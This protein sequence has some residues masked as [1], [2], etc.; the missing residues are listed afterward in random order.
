MQDEVRALLVRDGA[1]RVVG[2]LARLEV[3]DEA[4]VP[5]LALVL[6]ERVLQGLVADEE[7]ETAVGGGMEELE[8]KALDV[9]RPA[10][11]EPE[12]GRICLTTGTRGLEK[13]DARRWEK[14][15]HTLRRCRTK[16]ASFR[17][18]LR[19]SV[20]CVNSDVTNNI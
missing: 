15:V 11:V 4:L 7:G 16:N 9:R 13:F 5:W 1:V 20:E 19:R 18:Q 8:E 6:L 12:V 17:G 3:D 10:F 14:V 2:I